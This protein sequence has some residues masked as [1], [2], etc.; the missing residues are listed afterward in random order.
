MEALSATTLSKESFLSHE[1]KVWVREVTV[2]RI[3]I[4]SELFS[5][6]N[7]WPLSIQLNYS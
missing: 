5:N 2:K 6:P 1:T 3:S 7:N 4:A